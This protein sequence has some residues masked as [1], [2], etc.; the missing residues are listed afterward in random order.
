MLTNQRPFDRLYVNRHGE[1][2]LESR[3]PFLPVPVSDWINPILEQRSSK[4]LSNI[5]AY[6]PT[7]AS[8]ILKDPKPTHIHAQTLKNLQK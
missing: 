3:Q 5:Q 8:R 1:T 2:T 4:G 7:T 6:F